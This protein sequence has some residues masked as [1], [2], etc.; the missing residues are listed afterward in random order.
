[1][2]ENIERKRHGGALEELLK[3]QGASSTP[4]PARSPRERD[5]IEAAGRVFATADGQL[6]LDELLNFTLRRAS[7]EP[8]KTPDY[9]YFREG[10]NNI[11]AWLS[12]LV[13]K[14]QDPT[15]TAMEGTPDA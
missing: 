13:R 9:G 10:Q 8:G 2:A 6:V 7:W 11:A 15:P 12:L 14:S 3:F 4:V 1:M 5:L